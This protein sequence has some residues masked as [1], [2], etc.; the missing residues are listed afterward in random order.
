M[1]R[2]DDIDIQVLTVDRQNFNSEKDPLR[3]KVGP[4]KTGH[5]FYS[6]KEMLIDRGILCQ[7]YLLSYC[8]PIAVLSL[9]TLLSILAKT[10]SRID[11]FH[12]ANDKLAIMSSPP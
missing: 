9:A 1:L 12:S 11:V 2:Q 10:E 4:T 5:A 8:I 6:H 7:T 3:L